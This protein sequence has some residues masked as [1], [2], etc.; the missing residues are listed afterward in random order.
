M[1]ACAGCGGL[2]M[3]PGVDAYPLWQS[4]AIGSRPRWML[5]DE[6]IE[7]LAALSPLPSQGGTRCERTKNR[8]IVLVLSCGMQSRSSALCQGTPTSMSS[9]A[10]PCAPSC[11]ATRRMAPSA[12]LRPAFSPDG[13]SLLFTSDRDEPITV[14]NPITRLRGGE[15]YLLE[16]K[17]GG[18]R[19]RNRTQTC[20]VQCDQ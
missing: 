3:T 6:D 11:R 2:P 4:A 18:L 14:V 20:H 19:E 13:K 12:D 1:H 5:K 7:V 16:L 8:L 10:I 15:I 17:T 9:I